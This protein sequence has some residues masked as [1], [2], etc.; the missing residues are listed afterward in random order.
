MSDQDSAPVA[1]EVCRTHRGALPVTDHSDSFQSDYR[2]FALDQ[3]PL[4]LA[5]IPDQPREEIVIKII[6]IGKKLVPVEQVAFVEPFDSA[7]NPEFEP[8]KTTRAASS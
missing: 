1:E 5:F 4:P 7:A 8:E 3:R 6:T 2:P